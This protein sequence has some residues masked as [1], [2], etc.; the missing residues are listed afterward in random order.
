MFREVSEQLQHR[1]VGGHDT[2][3]ARIGRLLG[4]DSNVRVDYGDEIPG[5]HLESGQFVLEVLDV[6]FGG[7]DSDQASMRV[8]DR[9]RPYDDIAAARGPKT[10]D[11]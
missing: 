10:L 6:E 2:R 7:R 4:D 11:V 5:A 1:N 3:H 8:S 9:Q